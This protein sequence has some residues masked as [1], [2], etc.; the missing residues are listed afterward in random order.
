MR[1]RNRRATLI[2]ISLAFLFGSG[3]PSTASSRSASS[4]RVSRSSR[5]AS[6]WTFSWIS[7]MVLGPSTCQRSLPV[8]VDGLGYIVEDAQVVDDQT[9]SLGAAVG[10]VGAADGLQQRV[11]AERF[12][13]IHR[14]KDGRVE[15]GEELRSDDQHLERIGGVAEAVEELLLSV[16]L[17]AEGGVLVLPAVDRH[18]HVGDLRRQIL[19]ERPLVEQATLAVEGDHLR[20]EAT[21]R[22]LL[23]EV[24]GNVSADLL[25][26][27]RGLHQHR[28][29][30][31]GRRQHS[32]I[33]IAELAGEFLEGLVDGFLVDV[34]IE[35]ARL[36]VQRHGGAVADGLLEAVAAQVAC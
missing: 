4:T 10:A 21:Q 24:P 14:L 28:H 26:A 8:P 35:E 2:S 23:L 30:G 36:E 20:S 15:A 31:G 7:S 11:V 27:L 12:V 22:D 16:A 5:M 3:A 29:L 34:H 19:V 25:D 32:L 33:E 13:Q 18:D 6:T 1:F 17:A 9:V